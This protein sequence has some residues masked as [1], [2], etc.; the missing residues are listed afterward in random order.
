ML[1][2][3]PTSRGDCPALSYV[4][5][6]QVPSSQVS[7][8]EACPALVPPEQVVVRVLQHWPVVLPSVP[9]KDHSRSMRI[10]RGVESVIQETSLGGC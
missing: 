7:W 4:Q 1:L 10:V 6:I 9:M 8:M 3:L 5:L 2:L